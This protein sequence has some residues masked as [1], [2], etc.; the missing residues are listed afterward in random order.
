MAT[1]IKLCKSADYLIMRIV[2]REFKIYD[3]YLPWNKVEA[4][5]FDED[6]VT[7]RDGC[8][9]VTIFRYS[10]LVHLRVLHTVPY[11]DSEIRGRQAEIYLNEEDFYRFL[12][13][14]TEKWSAFLSVDPNQYPKLDFSNC[15]ARL[16]DIA[17]DP[18]IR[19]AFCKYIRDAFKWPGAK[20]I[21]IYNDFAPHSFYFE[22]ERYN[23]RGICGGIIL[24]QY[25]RLGRAK[26]E[27]GT[28]T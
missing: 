6:P 20:A 25:E 11:G 16:H 3:M 27:Y 26:C 14:P 4:A 13:N 8:D 18:Q 1:M 22:E 7:L 10:K 24:H 12:A 17:S 28:H 21:H 2:N 19:R 5:T 23:G 15:G 9:Y